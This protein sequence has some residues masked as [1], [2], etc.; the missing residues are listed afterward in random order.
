MEALGGWY[1]LSIQ[2]QC[3]QMKK[4]IR[5]TLLNLLQTAISRPMILIAAK[6]PKE[7]KNGGTDI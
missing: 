3:S 5:P 1:P 6:S 4:I 2:P 7:I